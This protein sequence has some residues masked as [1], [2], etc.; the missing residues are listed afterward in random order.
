[1][2]KL[3]LRKPKTYDYSEESATEMPRIRFYCVTEGD[4]ESSY[5]MGNIIF[6]LLYR[7]LILNCGC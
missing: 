7:I 6:V 4:T 1:M 2:E 5:F 3:N